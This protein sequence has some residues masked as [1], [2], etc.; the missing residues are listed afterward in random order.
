MNVGS[1]QQQMHMPD[2]TCPYRQV[3]GNIYLI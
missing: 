1:G 3:L 2:N